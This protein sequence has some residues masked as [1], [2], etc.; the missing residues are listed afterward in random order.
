MELTSDVGPSE[1][2]AEDAVG[3]TKVVEGDLPA[4]VESLRHDIERV[5]PH[6][7]NILRRDEDA[8]R[9]RVDSLTREAREAATWPLAL[10]VHAFLERMRRTDMSSEL[11]SS[12]EV[13][14][15][16]LLS[17]HGFSTFGRPGESFD[18]DRHEATST[19]SDSDDVRTWVVD[20]VI[21]AGLKW[22]ERVVQK[23]V[24]T[25][26]AGE[27]HATQREKLDSDDPQWRTGA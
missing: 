4:I 26:G 6:V 2:T 8:H 14:L 18:P 20:E 12:I 16:A 5:V 23:A 9:K 3:A 11:L 1:E 7:L 13:D 19:S 27:Q 17:A 21:V 22:L 24:V 15:G 10:G 25:V